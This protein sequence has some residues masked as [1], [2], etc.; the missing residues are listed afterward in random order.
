MTNNLSKDGSKH[1]TDEVFN[2]C[3]HLAGA[4]FALLGTAILIVYSSIDHKPWHIVGFAIY[5]FSLCGLFMASTLHH[6]MRASAST[7]RLLRSLDYGA[8]FLLIAGTMTPICLTVLRGPLGWCLLGVTWTVAI[9]GAV[10]RFTFPSLP[11]WITNT[12]YVSMGWFGLAAAWPVFKR[13]SWLGLFLLATGGIVYTIGALIY[14]VEKPNPIP[15]KFGFHEI[16]HIFVIVATL[17]IF[18]FMLFC[19]LPLP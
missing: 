13:L 15:A 19:I 2:T 7:E 1:A 3:S 9:C 18:L 4:I 10:L 8:V 6:G 11:K 5:G 17:I 14:A 12:L 16:W